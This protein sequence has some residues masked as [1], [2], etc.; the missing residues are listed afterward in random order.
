[1]QRLPITHYRRVPCILRVH[2][3]LQYI[4]DR[5]VTMEDAEKLIRELTNDFQ[6]KTLINKERLTF[7]THFL[8]FRGL[9]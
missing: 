4:D 1:M 2:G 3:Q 9:G 8:E 6:W 5:K 7:H